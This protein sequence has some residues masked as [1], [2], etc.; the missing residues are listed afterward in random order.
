MVKLEKE[1]EQL[2]RSVESVI[3]F[4][5]HLQSAGLSIQAVYQ[6]QNT[7]IERLQKDLNLLICKDM[8]IPLMTELIVTHE[9]NTQKAVKKVCTCRKSI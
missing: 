9:R 4:N 3:Q 7:E 8:A 5:T 1:Q 2:R 6:K